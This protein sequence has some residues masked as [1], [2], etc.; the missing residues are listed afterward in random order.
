[1]HIGLVER[2]AV[3]QEIGLAESEVAEVSAC[4]VWR[5]REAPGGNS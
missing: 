1:M 2:G 3:C 5:R 4:G